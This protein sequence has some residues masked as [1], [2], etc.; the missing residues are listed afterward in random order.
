MANCGESAKRLPLFNLVGD[1]IRIDAYHARTH[2]WIV[3]IE[4]IC[5]APAGICLLL[6]ELLAVESHIRERI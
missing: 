3:E 4:T 1:G 2:L 5:F 6:G